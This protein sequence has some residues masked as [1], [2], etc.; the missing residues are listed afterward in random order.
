MRSDDVLFAH[1][2]RETFTVIGI[3]THEV[4]YEISITPERH[5]LWQV[6]DEHSTRGAP[7]DSVVVPSIIATSG[8]PFRI[9]AMATEYARKIARIDPKLDDATYVAGLYRQ[10]G[11]SSPKKTKLEWRLHYLDLGL[12]DKRAD[13]FFALHKGPN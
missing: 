10:A 5:R 8:H 6:F 13:A 2:T 3:F 9:V 12:F 1:V 4:F 11:I 7:P